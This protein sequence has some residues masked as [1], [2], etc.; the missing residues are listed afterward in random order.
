MG[1]RTGN[2]VGAASRI[3]GLCSTSRRTSV[4]LRSSTRPITGF[5]VKG[6]TS[7]GARVRFVRNATHSS[8]SH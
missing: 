6:R 1:L 8:A 2:L 5:E 3:D 7:V 4:A